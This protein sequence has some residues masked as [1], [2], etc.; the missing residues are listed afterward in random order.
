MKGQDEL[1]FC[2]LKC[3]KT[4]FFAQ[5]SEFFA[6]KRGSPSDLLKAENRGG[7][8]EKVIQKERSEE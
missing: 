5:K 8:V 4:P 2:L 3:T 1:S 7:K 6:Q